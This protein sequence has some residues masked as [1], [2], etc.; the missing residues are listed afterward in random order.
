MAGKRPALI[1]CCALLAAAAVLAA[2]LV[3]LCF[4]V[5]R[6][7]SPRVSATVVGT[8]VSSFALLPAPALNLSFDVAVEA[9]NPNRAAFEYGEVVT[10]VRYHGDGVGRAVVPAGEIGARGSLA[11]NA[12]VE[13]DAARVA[14]SPYFPGEAIAGALPFETATTVAGRAVVLRVLRIRARSDVTCGVTVYPFRK[15]STP[16]QCAST[17]H[18]G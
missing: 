14:S 7:R 1:C 16:P 13:V 17:V 5:F 18:V 4:T 3:A 12:T 10:V 9:Y 8:R 6:P 2:V 15:E 11:A